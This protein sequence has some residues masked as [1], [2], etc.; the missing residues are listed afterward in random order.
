MKLKFIFSPHSMLSK[1][2]KINLFWGLLTQHWTIAEIK[3][4][5]TNLQW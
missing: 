1:I 4:L 3:L 5:Q 2:H